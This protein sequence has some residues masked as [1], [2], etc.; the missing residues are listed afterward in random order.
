MPIGFNIRT[1]TKPRYVCP[2]KYYTRKASF[3]VLNS[4]FGDGYTQKWK[5]SLLNRD[6]IITLKFENRPKEE[7]DSIFRFFQLYRGSKPFPY[8]VPI[9]EESEKVISCICENFEVEWTSSELGTIT[10]QLKQVFQLPL[11]IDIQPYVT[12]GFVSTAYVETG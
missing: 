4:K 12:T 5:E 9:S 10:A 7:I 11:F 8:R 2:D 1:V 6:E 3:N